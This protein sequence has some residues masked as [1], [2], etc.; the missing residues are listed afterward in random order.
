[1]TEQFILRTQFPTPNSL[2]TDLLSDKCC[3]N[4][5]SEWE[6]VVTAGHILDNYKGKPC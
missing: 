6:G 5:G 3:V 4:L 2:I 1:M